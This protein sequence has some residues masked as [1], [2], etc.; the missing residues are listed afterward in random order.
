M[1]KCSGSYRRSNYKKMK[2]DAFKRKHLYEI[3]AEAE[4]RRDECYD[5]KHRRF[6][7]ERTYS[8]QAEYIRKYFACQ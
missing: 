2:R 3:R 6:V 7:S 5:R 8:T 4:K 1:F